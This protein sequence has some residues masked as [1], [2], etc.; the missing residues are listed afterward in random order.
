MA[1]SS[2]Y[3][4]L[5]EGTFKTFS[6]WKTTYSGF[7]DSCH[8]ELPCNLLWMEEIL[9]QLIDGL[10]YYLWVSTIQGGAGFR[11]HPQHEENPPQTITRKARSSNTLKLT[12]ISKR[13]LRFELCRI[14]NP[15]HWQR[16]QFHWSRQMHRGVSTREC[17]L[18]KRGENSQEE[19]RSMAV[20]A[21]CSFE[22]SSNCGPLDVWKA[23]EA[24]HVE[25]LGT[26]M[27][28]HSWGEVP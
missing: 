16:M 21:R 25:A 28:C 24:Q 10:S 13:R 8:M 5:P 14:C 1:I 27:V 15:E 7:T 23:Q 6:N 17:P 22:K 4:K 12:F 26:Q 2:S 9:H 20:L 18:R 11:N 19:L 3:V